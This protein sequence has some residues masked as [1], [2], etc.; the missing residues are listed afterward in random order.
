MVHR[1]NPL[2]WIWYA[3]GAKLP[4][5]YDGWVLKDVTS[6]FWRLRALAR[7]LVQFAPFAVLILIFLPS[8]MWVRWMGVLGGVIVGLIYALAYQDEAAES[9]ALKAG[10]P[11]GYAGEIREERR[12]PGP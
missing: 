6:R 9:R 11:R 3:F 5:R 8:E 12:R 4:A 10:W 2:R 1:P 7:S